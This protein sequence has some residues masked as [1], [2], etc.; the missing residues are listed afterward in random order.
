M[1]CFA[2][3]ESFH[4]ECTPLVHWGLTGLGV[5]AAWCDLCHVDWR[6]FSVTDVSLTCLAARNPNT[7]GETAMFTSPVT[8]LPGPA[9][10][11]LPPL[12]KQNG[13]LRVRMFRKLSLQ[14]CGPIWFPYC[15]RGTL[16]TRNCNLVT[17]V[18]RDRVRGH[19]E[20]IRAEVC[21]YLVFFFIMPSYVYLFICLSYLSFQVPVG[22]R[23]RAM[24][25]LFTLMIREGVV[26]TAH[27]RNAHPDSRADTYGQ[28][29]V[30]RC[31]HCSCDPRQKWDPPQSHIY[32]ECGRRGEL[33]N[34]L[35][36]KLRQV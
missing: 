17:Q 19:F 35:I 36:S 26:R 18:M 4:R 15:V 30:Q 1:H 22:A 29:P 28:D 9:L 33:R 21:S 12:K 27:Y 25:F 8:R 6:S 16:C 13:R 7:R 24:S 10:G 32:R 5:P 2:C 20:C 3:N 31:P 11:S 34:D 23:H 14:I